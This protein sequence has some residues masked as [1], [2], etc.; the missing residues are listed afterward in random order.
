MFKKIILIG[1]P[2]ILLVFFGFYF[3]K[4][5]EPEMILGEVIKTDI[6][7]K[8][9]ENGRVN[10][11]D[12]INLNFNASGKIEE[13]YVE[14]GD[15]VKFGQE[16]ARLEADDI[17]IQ[18]EEAQASLETAKLDLK[19]LLKG[20]SLEEVRIAETQVDSAAKSLSLAEKNL[21]DSYQDA[22][23]SLNSAYSQIYN[24]FDFADYLVDTYLVVYD[25]DGRKILET[26][27]DAEE[28]EEEMKDCLKTLT[29]SQKKEIEEATSKMKA[30]LE[31]T[32]SNL[33]S[34]RYIVNRNDDYEDDVSSSDKLSLDSLRTEVNLALADVVSS[35]QAISSAKLNLES[36]ETSLTEMRNR[37]SLLTA[38]AEEIDI[39]IYRSRIKQ[40]E[41]RIKLYE[42][43]LRQK[44]IISPID[45][46]I[47]EV[48]KRVGELVQ[49]VSQGS[50][51]VVIPEVPYK[52]E[53]DIYEEDIIKISLGSPVEI[54]LAAFPENY[55]KGRVVK[56]DP[57]EKVI[58]G[59]VYYS[60]TISFEE[61]PEGIKPGM[62]ADVS[63]TADLKENVLAVPREA[64][65]RKG[66]KNVVEVFDNGIKEEREVEIGIRGEDDLVE[67]ISGLEEKEKIIL[68]R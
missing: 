31:N 12:E 46:K 55:F 42:N 30:H 64:V 9:F 11:G 14:V 43:Q 45:G 51:I 65:Q 50:V 62:T 32:F 6:V 67:I 66:S 48:N 8:I 57:S 17:Y 24:T 4:N 34:V 38:E 47:I 35:Q 49:S 19:K 27:D 39:E 3:F 56:V 61:F 52:V 37:L 63:I 15:E 40:A 21:K 23:T 33:D 5:E 13:I 29:S 53:T 41:A 59:V 16:L 22:L 2:I 26:R 36:A 10:K 68:N 58:D 60:V 7:Q 25:I 20:V 28:A 18:L 1:T 54:N 44:K